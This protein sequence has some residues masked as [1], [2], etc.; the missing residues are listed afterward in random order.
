MSRVITKHGLSFHQHADY[1]RIYI[2]VKVYEAAMAVHRLTE[3]S[4][5]GCQLAS[6]L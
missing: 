4:V 5:N 6:R 3:P 1:S 2:S